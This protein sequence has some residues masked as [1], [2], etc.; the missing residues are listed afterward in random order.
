MKYI[1]K[2][3]IVAINNLAVVQKTKY[4]KSIVPKPYNIYN[5]RK[6]K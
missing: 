1:T 3:I 5:S 4:S 2:K 6:S